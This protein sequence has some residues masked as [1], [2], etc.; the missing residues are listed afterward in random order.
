MRPSH[1][2][3]LL[4]TLPTLT[5]CTTQLPIYSR[6]DGATVIMDEDRELGQTPLLLEEQAWVWTKHTLTFVREGYEPRTVEVAAKVRPVNLALCFVGGCLMWPLWPLALLGEYR[7]EL[8]VRLE[9]REG[10]VDPFEELEREARRPR[11][12]LEDGPGIDFQ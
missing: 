4:V 7:D 12:A 1:A 8:V 2:L 11:A 3:A 6:P 5:A 9:P 10:D